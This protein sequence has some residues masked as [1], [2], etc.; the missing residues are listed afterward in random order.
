MKL[1]LS[2]PDL[3]V[4]QLRSDIVSGRLAPG[5]PLRQ[6]EIAR[7]FGVSHVPVREAFLRLQAERLVEIRP[8]RGAIVAELSA[9]EL[10]ELNEM[11]AA[12][13]CCALRIAMPKFTD[14]DLRKAAQVLD[15]IDQQPERWAEL[16]TAFHSLLYA[17]AERPRQ[18]ATILS[19]QRSLERY[20]YYV[21]YELKMTD[22]FTDSQR[23]HRKLLKL[24]EAR[25]TEE[26]CSLVND[27]ILEP[28]GIVVAKL[29][30]SGHA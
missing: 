28:W 10:E 17:R 6:D 29:R 18:L 15:R 20:V 12:L 21:Y 26:A 22:A 11:R 27:H 13:E 3:I 24:I 9:A 14:E 8:R 25:K 19:L 4:R 30:E 1:P 16:N 23:E 7:S 5:E 2:T